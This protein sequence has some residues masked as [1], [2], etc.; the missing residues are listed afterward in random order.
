MR[1]VFERSSTDAENASQGRLAVAARRARATFLIKN[2]VD[3]EGL[4]RLMPIFGLY[5]R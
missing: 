5:G 2:M 4:L 1:E 3:G